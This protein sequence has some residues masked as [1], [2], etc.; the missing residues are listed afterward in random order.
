MA[1]LG[2][3]KT[4]PNDY[5]PQHVIVKGTTQFLNKKNFDL[6]IETNAPPEKES[7]EHSCNDDLPPELPER[8]YLEDGNN[9]N[10]IPELPP[11][12]YMEEDNATLPGNEGDTTSKLDHQHK[13]TSPLSNPS[14]NTSGQTLNPVV[15]TRSFKQGT[16]GSTTLTGGSTDMGQIIKKFKKSKDQLAKEDNS[17]TGDYTPLD[18]STLDR[19]Q[20]QTSG[21]QDVYMTLTKQNSKESRRPSLDS[22]KASE[23]KDSDKEIETDYECVDMNFR[24]AQPIASG[25]RNDSPYMPLTASTMT[26]ETAGLAKPANLKKTASTNDVSSPNSEE[27]TNTEAPYMILNPRNKEI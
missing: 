12:R 26:R 13:H 8:G 9:I 16:N 7:K 24:R 19:R 3:D 4:L 27:S 5:I 10:E 25:N 2:F 6:F 23:K 11:R 21:L 22:K 18:F 20:A 15:P 1:A 17:S 14:M